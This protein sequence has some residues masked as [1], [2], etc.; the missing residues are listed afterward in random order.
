MI[1]ELDVHG[2][3]VAE[4]RSLIDKALK[5]LK[6]ETCVLRIIH[7]YSHGDAIG[8]MVRSRYRK[9]PKIERVELSMNRGIMDLIIRRIL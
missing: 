8:K 7:G 6:K 1:E 4:A 2:L 5:S 9:H 3:S